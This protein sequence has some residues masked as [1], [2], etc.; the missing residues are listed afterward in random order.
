[1][2]RRSDLLRKEIEDYTDAHLSDGTLHELASS[3]GYSPIYMGTLVKRIFGSSF[4]QLLQSKRCE[5][6]AGLLLG[7]SL[8]ISTIIHQVGYENES[9]FRKIFR[10]KYKN[11]PLQFRNRKEKSHVK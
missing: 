3:L 1:M 6:A 10:E 8:P 7:T 4:S 2:S 9:F 11:T 5:K